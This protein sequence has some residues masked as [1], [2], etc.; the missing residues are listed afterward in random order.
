MEVRV[1]E[2]EVKRVNEMLNRSIGN[3]GM[4]Y[5]GGSWAGAAGQSPLLAGF[6]IYI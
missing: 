6:A 2:A 5:F 3:G 1:G 4:G